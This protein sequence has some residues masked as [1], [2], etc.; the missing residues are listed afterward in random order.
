[1]QNLP[2]RVVHE[3]ALAMEWPVASLDL[4]AL[5]GVFVE[6]FDRVNEGVFAERLD[7]DDVILERSID[8]RAADGLVFSV[9]VHWLTERERFL[10]DLHAEA[11]RHRRVTRQEQPSE[12]SI[13][14]AT[15]GAFD[16]P[17]IELVIVNARVRAMF[18]P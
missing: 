10:K 5:R 11:I 2:S 14:R 1:M 18:V 15:L 16:G 6:L 13:R 17:G 12:V 3:V 4:T 8:V 9:P 7:C